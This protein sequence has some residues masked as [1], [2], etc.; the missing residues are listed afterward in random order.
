[1]RAAVF[2]EKFLTEGEHLPVVARRFGICQEDSKVICLRRILRG[3]RLRVCD[4]QILGRLFRGQKLLIGI[5]TRL[6]CAERKFR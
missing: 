6:H 2:P 5:G 1:M 4:L 3:M